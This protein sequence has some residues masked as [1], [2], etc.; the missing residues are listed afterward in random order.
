MSASVLKSA[1]L[2]DLRA[3]VPLTIGVTSHRNIP[4]RE[5][6][7]IRE[8]VREFLAR[9]RSEFPQ[10]PLMVLS[11]LA[12]GGDQWVAEEAIAAGIRLVA[13]LPLARAQYALD[14]DD[15]AARA[16]Y[17]SL[18]DAAEIIE[19]PDIGRKKP[20]NANAAPAGHER[21]LH[22]LQAGVFISQHCH[23]LLAIWDG[24][25]SE[26]TGGTGQVVQFHL[27]GVRP[28]RDDRRRSIARSALLGDDDRLVFHIVCSRDEPSGTPAPPLEP[29]QTLWRSGE[30]M[31]PG[32][33]PMPADFRAMLVQAAE[34]N[35]D[36]AKYAPRIDTSPSTAARPGAPTAASAIERLFAAGDWLAIHF[37]LRVLFSMRT[38]YTLA[39]LMGIA[40][41]AYDNLSAQDDLIFV[42]LVLFVIGAVIV[43]IAQRRSWHRK[44]LDYRALAEGLRVQSYWRRAG[45]AITGESEFAQDNFLQKQDV[46]L[47]WIRNVMRSAALE[48]A[49][50]VTSSAPDDLAN[51]V[52]EWVGAPGKG[53]QLDYYARKSAQRAQTHKFTEAL[54]NS[55]LLVGIGIA[56]ALAVFARQ[57]SADAKN[58]LVVIMGVFS[59]LAAVRE[60][61]AYRKADK[62]LIKQYRYM[63]QLFGAARKALDRTT[64]AA[65]QREILRLLGEASLAEHVEWALMNRQRPLEHGRL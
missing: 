13:P 19:V 56:I 20:A 26:R 6:P 32:D 48:S 55:S 7:A 29:L 15:G 62:E 41:T 42:F 38:L 61:Y 57:M 21:D 59:I 12:E 58:W 43:Y 17:E 8:R 30:L 16:R 3:A 22:Y 60:A 53:G 4:A 51:V 10:L 63:A 37:Q 27:T 5:E 49:L 1:E 24:K 11:S 45:I 47:A 54:G 39:A 18:C 33:G 36:W 64:D 40:F 14:F 35:A 9:L 52:R 44:Y 65:E 34:F 28:L 25:T 46:E 50:G 23:I 2:T 31:A